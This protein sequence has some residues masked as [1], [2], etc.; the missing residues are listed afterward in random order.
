MQDKSIMILVPAYEDF[1]LPRTIEDAIG[2][3]YK[4]TRLRFVIGL[5][6]KNTD[7]NDFINKYK[8]DDRF[9]FVT[10]NV[11][12]R[13]GVNKI[14]HELSGYHN[15]EDYLL[16]IDSHM[17]FLMYWDQIIINRYSD[18]QKE[19]GS[20]VVWSRP[21]S[22]TPTLA[23]ETGEINDVI[24]WIPAIDEHHQQSSHNGVIRQNQVSGSWDGKPFKKSSWL[25]SHFAFMDARWIDE[26]GIES[27][28]HQFCEEQ[29]AT[30]RTYM[31]GWDI[32]Y[33]TL[34]Y[35]IGHNVSKTNMAL[36]G[37]EDAGYFDKQFGGVDSNEIKNEVTKF[38]LTGNSKVIA[39]KNRARTV[40][41]FY[42]EIGREDLV[43]ALRLY[44]NIDA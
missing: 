32:Y 9:T 11:D 36:Y 2:K 7:I 28:V 31:S 6:Y 13:P 37:K 41:D 42:R 25:T 38:L 10:Y 20:N 23:S 15:E 16:M 4:P 40:D 26:V 18:M 43:E 33:D 30:I 5:Q 12:D 3:A 17:H 44:F 29:L 24:D 14:R 35:P 1:D 34:L 8:D 19:F 21:M 27:S 22:Q 39:L